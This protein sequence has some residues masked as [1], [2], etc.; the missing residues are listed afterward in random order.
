MRTDIRSIIKT[1]QDDVRDSR[2]QIEYAKK[3]AENGDQELA[4]MHKQDA[5]MRVEGL[6]RWCEVAKRKIGNDEIGEAMI[7]MFCDQREEIEKNLM[8]I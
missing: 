2:M 6:K 8:K 4:Q 3:A 1:V 5:Q 7:D